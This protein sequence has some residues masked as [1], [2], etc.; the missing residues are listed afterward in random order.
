MRVLERPRIPC[1]A[2]VIIYC[3]THPHPP[4]HTRLSLFGTQEECVTGGNKGEEEGE[5]NREEEE[6]GGGG[7]LMSL[8]PFALSS[9]S[10]LSYLESLL[11][12]RISAPF[13]SFR[14][15]LSA[16]RSPSTWGGRQGERLDHRPDRP[17]LVEGQPS[18]SLTASFSHG[19][20]ASLQSRY[21]WSGC[22]CNYMNVE[23]RQ[24][25]T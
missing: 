16:F 17:L 12:T 25:R 10:L 1:G 7:S 2:I 3:F 8:V 5:G 4:P 11:M 22:K 19:S 23:Q 13:S 21:V 6:G 18:T 24:R 20:L 14:R 15:W 9:R